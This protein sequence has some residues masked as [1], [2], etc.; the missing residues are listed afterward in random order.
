MSSKRKARASR[1]NG[2]LSR[3]P[4]SPAGLLRA[5]TAAITHDLTASTTVLATESQERFNRLHDTFR[6]LH[7]PANDAEALLV[8]QLAVTQWHLRRLWGIENALLNHEVDTLAPA[9]AAAYEAL[10]HPTRTALAWRSLYDETRAHSG[11]HRHLSRLSRQY[12]RT[13]AQ[14]KSIK[15][16]SAAAEPPEAAQ[17]DQAAKG[18]KQDFE[19]GPNPKNGHLDEEN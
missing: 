9:H 2:Q 10:D 4:V 6:T 16:L 11:L 13:L 8:E 19:D 3:G 15:Q 1:A 7:Q 5:K 14:L 18:K 17:M 12:E